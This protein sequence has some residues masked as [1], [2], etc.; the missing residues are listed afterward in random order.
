MFW[1]L[2][3]VLWKTL[4]EQGHSPSFTD[5]YSTV[6]KPS[7]YHLWFLYALIGLYLTVPILRKITNT[8]TNTILFYY[9]V[10]WFIAVSL[11]PLAEKVLGHNSQ[12]DLSSISG[13]I[14]YFVLGL[15][16]GRRE[17]STKVFVI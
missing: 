8:A 16:L 7:Y 5:I 3:F 2:F 9:C 1:S 15:I 10:I 4:F 11:I 14:G 12:F 6:L 17:I 13:F